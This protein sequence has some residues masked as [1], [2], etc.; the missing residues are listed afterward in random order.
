MKRQQKSRSY[1]Y[2]RTRFFLE[3]Q[4]GSIV[5]N[6]ALLPLS[7]FLSV[8]LDNHGLQDIYVVL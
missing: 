5:D 7:E 8:F 4:E 1:D 6:T 2:D 3:F